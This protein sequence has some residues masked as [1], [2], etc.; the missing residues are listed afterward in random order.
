MESL[1]L[2]V[3]IFLV[4]YALVIILFNTVMRKKLKVKRKKIFS[5]NHLNE[6]HKKIDWMIRFSFILVL[7]I[8]YLYNMSQEIYDPVWFM[9]THTLLLGFILVSEVARAI[10]EK[11][12]AENKNDYKFTLIQT[13]FI[14]VTLLSFFATDFLGVFN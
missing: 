6:K 4:L 12:Y 9:E 1:L 13:G 14:A 5:Y 2:K 8:S 10:M 3:I 11:R 7:I